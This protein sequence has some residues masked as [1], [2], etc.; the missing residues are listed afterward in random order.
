MFYGI[1]AILED[2]LSMGIS[3]QVEIEN[4]GV[5][6]PTHWRPQTCISIRPLRKWARVFIKNIAKSNKQYKHNLLQ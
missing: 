1:H 5:P 2:K 4:K 3:W 6:T